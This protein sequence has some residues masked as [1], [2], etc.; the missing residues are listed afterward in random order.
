MIRIIGFVHALHLRHIDL[1]LEMPIKK[2]IIYIKLAKS[3]LAIEGNV[4]HNTDTN[5]IDHG[6]KSFMKVNARLLVKAF[7]N[8]ASFMPCIRSVWILLDAKHPFVA[9]YILP[10][11]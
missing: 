9:H 2:V 6:T 7:G 1:L 4:K 10:R 5:G 3:P 11:S 8:K